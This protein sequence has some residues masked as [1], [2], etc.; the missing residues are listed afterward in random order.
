MGDNVR[1]IETEVRT[2]HA[3]GAGGWN[4][5]SRVR[6]P[7]KLY[8]PLIANTFTAPGQLTW[9]AAKVGE[10]SA[11]VDEVGDPDAGKRV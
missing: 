4:A 3:N 8:S 5:A 2:A 11:V 9:F 7:R 1:A 6:G 10:F